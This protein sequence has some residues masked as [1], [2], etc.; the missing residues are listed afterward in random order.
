MQTGFMEGLYFT[1]KK[2]NLYNAKQYFIIKSYFIPLP[3]AVR[4]Q[5]LCNQ[6]PHLPKLTFCVPSHTV[7]SS[8]I[9]V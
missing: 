7:S 1:I 6:K 3:T 2:F 8:S 9:M 5:I 4:G